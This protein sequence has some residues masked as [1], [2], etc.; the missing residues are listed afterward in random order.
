M[1]SIHHRYIKLLVEDDMD[2]VEIPE[3]FRMAMQVCR[4]NELPNALVISNRANG[5]ELRAGLRAALRTM[6]ARTMMPSVRLG[7]IALNP[8][9]LK[10]FQA[11][12]DLADDNFIPSRI[13]SEEEA[14]LARFAKLDDGKVTAIRG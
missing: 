14:G 2:L 13:F 3:A 12:K 7:L 6:L 10:A 9:V 11:L 4:F 5:L 1:L 8:E